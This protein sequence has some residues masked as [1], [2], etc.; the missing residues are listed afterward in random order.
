DHVCT[1]WG[2]F[3]WK[4]FDGEFFTLPTS[5]QH[6]LVSQCKET[7]ETFNIQMTRSTLNN[8]TAI[9]RII[10]KLD[11]VVVEMSSGS[12][13][14]DGQAI[15]LPFIKYGV[16]VTSTSSSIF[17]DSGQG[18][19]AIWNLDDSLDIE[20]DEKYR[21]QTCGLCGDFDGI[22]NGFVDNGKVLLMTDFAETY[23]V[24]TPGETC[25]VEE[26]A[27]LQICGN[28]AFCE[29]L[30]TSTPFSSCKDLLDNNAFVKICMAD[31]CFSV[32]NTYPMLCKTV[33]EYS[34]QCVHA[35]GTPQQ[36]RKPNFCE[37]SCPFNMEFIECGSS[38]PDTCS[39]PQV[40]KTCD[41]HCH[42]GCSCPNGTIFDDIGKTG[43][44]AVDQCPCLH[45]KQ[46]YM[47]GQSYY[48]NCRSCVCMNGRWKCTE[49]NCPGTCSVMGGA[50]IS[51]FDG[52]DY[53]F[54]GDCSY[55]K[56]NTKSCVIK[57]FLCSLTAAAE[58]IAFK[59]S[60]FYIFIKI[61]MG[62][63]IVIQLSP[64]MQVF[65]TV[66]ASIRG[67]TS[68][69]CG[70]FN[71]KINDDFMGISGLVEG[72]AAAF[73]NTW[74]TKA[75]CPDI[76]TSFV[77][78]C[79]QGINTES[80]ARYWCY[81]LIDPKEV[82]APCHHAVDPNSYKDMCMYD[83]CNSDKSEDCMCT[84][85]SAYVFACS[86]AGIHLSGWR[87]NICGKQNKDLYSLLLSCHR[88]CRFLGQVDHSCQASFTSVDGCGCAEGTYM[89]DKGTCVPSE[90]CP[91]YEKDEVI[92]A[93]QIVTGL[94]SFVI[95]IFV[96]V[97]SFFTGPSKCFSP[98]VYFNCSSAQPGESGTE[99]ERSCN[100]LDMACVSECCTSG[101]M[102]PKGL[103][104]DGQ[105]GC[106]TENN[107]PCVHNGQV[108]HAG[109]TL[110]VDCN[111]CTC[112]N[113]KFICTNNVCDA[114]CDI[115]GDGHYTTFDDKRFD[116]NGQCEYTLLQVKWH[117]NNTL[118]I[119]TENVACGSLGT[120]CSKTIKILLGVN[121]HS[122]TGKV[123]G[124]CGNY[125]GNSQ[126][127]FT[128]RSLDVVADVLEFGNSWKVSS[129]CPNAQSIKDPCASNG[130]RASWAK[131]Q[132]SIINSVTFSSCHSQVDPGPYY[133][134]CVR[135][136]CACD[137]GGDC[138]CF[139]TA[140]AAYAKTCNEAG[141]CVK[142]RTPK[143]CPIFCDYY[144]AP[145][146]CEWHYKPC[147]AHCM[148][149]CRNP[150]GI[151]SNLTTALEEVTK[152]EEKTPQEVTEN[153]V[154]TTKPPT[155][156]T[157][158]PSTASTTPVVET[159]TKPGETTTEPEET[160]VV[161]SK[162]SVV[163]TTT[164][165]PE[166]TTKG[167]TKAG[168]T[169]ISEATT[170]IGETTKP[171]T[172]TTTAPSTASTTPVVETTTKPGE[173]TTKPGETTVVTSKPSVV[174]TTTK[175]P[176][177]TT[178][179]TTKAGE[180]TISE[181]TTNIGETTK[182][183]TVTTTA[184]STASTT[185]VV[186]TTTKPGETTTKPEETT[187]VTSKPSVLTTTTKA[188]ETTTKG[189]TKAGETTISEATTK[190]G[191]TTKP[192]T[193]TTTAPST[194]S[195]TPVVETTTKQEKQQPSQEKQQ[196]SRQSPLLSP[197]LPKH[198][199]LQLKEQQRLERQPYQ[200]QQQRL[201]RQLNHQQ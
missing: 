104:S 140:V 51:T 70:N 76:S 12:V 27:Q 32:S 178:K 89:N 130:Y 88:T 99:C 161:T 18:I 122:F 196:L 56:S 81:K 147:G 141:A 193:V 2:N 198:Q 93:G 146:G 144:N 173:T 179:G 172:V 197:Q 150:S 98:T 116:F 49:E 156:S 41:K 107:C 40:S 43:C 200:K 60:S 69:L 139:C 168:E 170:K 182:P 86:V 68:G 39:T 95:I 163:T 159:T 138:E 54:H 37:K 175:A 120:T 15:K 34:R 154:E 151:C 145:G 96:V 45:N 1:M 176:E 6:V 117:G 85:V 72:T 50:H 148:K 71:N 155:V 136:S 152:A 83:S 26:Q 201:V 42:D 87:K 29:N 194:A 21:N 94:W 158:A 119:I 24:S 13:K 19:K 20:M 115:Y 7:Y 113:R 47:P 166:T 100:N 169:T 48:H 55:L 63:R 184:P 53:T 5:C 52:K 167:T 191:E 30:F 121:T 14:V 78:P 123:C 59:Q 38:C 133:E 17:V 44:V 149:T 97:C 195:T 127:D 57:L 180:T 177:T 165:A 101:C 181:A 188:P 112:Q 28:K 79:N 174:T 187:V 157:T 11:G 22:A 131:R 62:L 111:T 92:P 102:C 10:M 77:H 134:S 9:S 66:D 84:A 82:F 105:G 36:W 58:L 4:T 162:P 8:V 125:D 199:K 109:Q 108:F 33:S 135:D 67:T 186:E 16:S 129:N 171:P 189:T 110:T 137:S 114:V 3:H 75:S 31:K 164:K 132:C 65:I 160:T 143:I 90:D 190:I 103:V 64:R 124:L 91:C 25:K 46:V 183:P 153:I 73:V 192:P 128:T 126:N 35:G 118:Q 23:K 80:F 185:P 61:K 142:W 74:K 106:V